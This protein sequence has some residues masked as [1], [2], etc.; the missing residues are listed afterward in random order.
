MTEE[1][2]RQ[3]NEMKEIVKQLESFMKEK[4]SQQ[5]SLPVDNASIEVLA[6]A[7]QDNNYVIT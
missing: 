4:K 3:F 6:R 2:K 5:I 1:E 7:L